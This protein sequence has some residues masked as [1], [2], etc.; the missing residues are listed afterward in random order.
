MSLPSGTFQ[1]SY[2]QDMAII[3]TK[4][5]WIFLL[6]F[7]VILFAAPLY[8]NN[9]L[10]TLMTIIGITVI[11]VQGLNIL[12]GRCGLISMG[13]SGFMMVG[14]YASAI[15]CAKAGLPFWL[16][17]PAA[18]LIAGLT[19][20]IF[21]LPSLKVRG[22]YLVMATI[23]AYFIIHW[24]ILQFQGV[25]GGVN[26]LAI[27]KATIFGINLNTKVNYFYLVMII[28]VVAVYLAK[29][30]IRT[31]AG[32][33]FVAIR[34]NDL[35]AEVMGVNLWS[36][37]LQAFFI[38]C[39]FAGVAGAL[40]AQYLRFANVDQFPFMDSVWFLGMLIV[41]GQGSVTGVIFGVVALKLLD[42]F[43]IQIGPALVTTFHVL[44][45][46]GAALSLVLSGLIVILF[47]IFEPHGM[48]HF[49][50]RIKS[51]YRLWPFSN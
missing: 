35:A 41:G 32:R 45:T 29:N 26:G 30:I 8:A 46:A 10:M 7:L 3:R 9:S 27:P 23:A 16:S 19:G 48:V 22:F 14:G 47:L 6:L 34:D 20:I 21:G 5:Q 42:Q 25:T 15:L 51:W 43:A 38:G 36:Y 4:T 28:A 1:E 44:P 18:G 2:A 11:S 12:T 31:R 37:K 33:A 13:H 17:L 49:W 24:V 50:E 39:V 40:S